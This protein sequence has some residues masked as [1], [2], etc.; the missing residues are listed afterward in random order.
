MRLKYDLDQARKGLPLF[1]HND[2][3]GGLETQA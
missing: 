2:G 1:A 3:D